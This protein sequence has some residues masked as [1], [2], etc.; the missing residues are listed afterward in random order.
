MHQAGVYFKPRHMC[1][2]CRRMLWCC[3]TSI[4]LLP[5]F[6]TKLTED[7]DSVTTFRVDFGRQM[8][9]DKECP[10]SGITSC[11]VVWRMGVR[12]GSV[13]DECCCL[14]E[15]NQLWH[16]LEDGCE[17]WNL[18]DECCCLN[19]V[20]GIFLFVSFN[21]GHCGGSG[22][23]DAWMADWYAFHF[24]SVFDW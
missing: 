19:D 14:N 6:S 4:V 21:I 13:V 3:V 7:S 8:H 20:Q 5:K 9:R 24:S 16:S 11:D 15:R 2:V 10:S 1:L 12:L 18:A 17:A 22:T 23:H